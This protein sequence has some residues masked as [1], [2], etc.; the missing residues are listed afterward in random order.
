[1]KA[2]NEG[3]KRQEEIVDTAFKKVM[4]Q[5][6]AQEIRY[7]TYGEI[8]TGIKSLKRRKCKDGSGWNNE[9]ILNGGE[10]MIKSLKKI[11]NEIENGTRT[12]E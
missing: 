5:A 9:V 1:M 8:R 2:K 11:F 10:E 3:E 12:V 7:T 6:A 4:E